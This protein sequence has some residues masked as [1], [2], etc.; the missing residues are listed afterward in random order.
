MSFSKNK[1]ILTNDMTSSEYIK[2]YSLDMIRV[3][4]E[5]F[6][7]DLEEDLKEILDL[8]SR[9]ELSIRVFNMAVAEIYNLFVSISADSLYPLSTKM[10]K[11]FYATKVVPLKHNML[12][13]FGQNKNIE[14]P[15]LSD[16]PSES[17]IK[18]V[19]K[20][21]E[22]IQRDK[23]INS[24]TVKR[25]RS[26]LDPNKTKFTLFSIER[27]ILNVTRPR[28]DGK[29]LNFASVRMN[30]L[31]PIKKKHSDYS[32]LADLQVPGP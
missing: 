2:K 25:L 1:P 14:V 7:N 26:M 20:S 10:W 13:S 9:S 23:I 21:M 15:R 12:I 5:P 22:A 19:E 11:Y 30:D 17:N 32:L 27:A 31:N 29:P 4:Q 28:S 8:L 18:V 6:L 3:K 16:T 24:E